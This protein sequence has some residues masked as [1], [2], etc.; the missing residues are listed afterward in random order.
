MAILKILFLT[1]LFPTLS[2][3][4][5]SLTYVKTDSP[6]DTMETFIKAMNDY[7]EGVELNIPRQ[8]ARIYDAIRCFAEK[9]HAVITS[10]REKELA[11][12]F[13]K[14][15]IDR[16]LVIDFSKIPDNLEKPRWRLKGTEI[17]LKPQTEGERQGEWLITEGTWR[18]AQQFYERAGH[19]PYLEGSGH[20][21]LYIQPWME[22]YLPE[23]SKQETLR[24]KNWQWLGL[25]F[26][27]FIG[28]FLRL[29]TYTT[30]TLYKNLSIY[31]D[32]RWKKDLITQIEKPVALIAASGFWYL[33]IH[34]LKLE[35]L[36]YA[37]V[38][39]LIQIIFG[40][41]LTWAVYKCA[42]VFG[43]QLKRIA[44]ETE[45]VLDDQ[46]VP[47]IDK[48]IKITIVLLGSLLVLQ[49]MGVNVFSLLAGLGLG[50]LAFALA[51]KDT[52]ANL[53]GSIMILIDRPFQVGDWVKVGEV[54]GNIEEIGFRSTRVRTFYNSLITVPNANMATMEIDN[55]G[56]RQYRRTHTTLDITYDTPKDKIAS[57]VQGIR[58]IVLDNPYSRKDLMHIYFA[59][60][61]SS[62]LQIMVYFFLVT[63]D[64]GEELR[65][66]ESIFFKIYDLAAELGVEFAYPTQ[67][68]Y[69]REGD[70]LFAPQEPRPPLHNQDV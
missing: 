42:N 41:A 55:M 21:A 7:K 46:L 52:A 20:G 10:Q 33:W 66:R 37:L 29:L 18:R 25:L 49:N 31:G 43:M 9:D 36:S 44:Q 16:V 19:L 17:V 24:L 2:L 47:F 28:L 30:L 11:A 45:S 13:L 63:S 1:L 8:R 15:F 69:L 61:A 62:S 14:E 5:E 34:Y 70:E 64:W 56:A 51:A 40:I 27:F 6:R 57:F 59:G 12:I 39:G 26:G 65:E 54:D 3:G 35:G 67:T 23:W 22:K 4:F 50:G 58:Q 60:Y 53:F 32:L 38:N 48:A 68:L